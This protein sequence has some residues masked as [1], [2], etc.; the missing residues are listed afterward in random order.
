MR[1]YVIEWWFHYIYI[2]DSSQT[3]Q[4]QCLLPKITKL[5]CMTKNILMLASLVK[6]PMTARQLTEKSKSWMQKNGRR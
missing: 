6:Q 1:L 2:A 3:Q 5:A 4:N